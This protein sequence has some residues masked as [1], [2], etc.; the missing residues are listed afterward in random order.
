MFLGKGS[1]R[2]AGFRHNDKEFSSAKFFIFP[3]SGATAEQKRK[4]TNSGRGLLSARHPQ[5]VS[6]FP[7]MHSDLDK[8]QAH[9]HGKE[10]GRV[11][12]VQKTS[13]SPAMGGLWDAVDTEKGHV[14]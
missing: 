10:L 7:T 2:W 1:Q 9:P 13:L 4:D 14:K 8:E 12:V 5:I 11:E 6:V 3:V